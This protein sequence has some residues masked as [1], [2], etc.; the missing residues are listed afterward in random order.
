MLG[1]MYLSTYRLDH[2]FFCETRAYMALV[3]GA[4]M[5]VIMLVFMFKM[6]TSRRE[7][8]GIIVGSAAIFVIAL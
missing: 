5:A 6:Y 1:L 7:N 3:M 4:T 8:I 2:L